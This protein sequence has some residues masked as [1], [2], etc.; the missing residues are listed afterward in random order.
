MARH[1]ADQ[2]LFEREGIGPADAYAA[3]KSWR[4]AVVRQ[5][6]L[7][8][9]WPVSRTPDARWISNRRTAIATRRAAVI[10]VLNN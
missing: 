3:R 6:L 8:R 2:A 9:S 10:H 1:A 4:T 7:V 5:A